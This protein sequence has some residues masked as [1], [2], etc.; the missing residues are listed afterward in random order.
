MLIFKDTKYIK[1][2]FDNEAELEKVVIDNYEY[3]FGPDSFYLPK[4]LIKT[5]DGAGTIPDGFAID[6][7]LKKWYVV[8]AELG[9][10]DVWNHIAK[11]VSKQIVASLQLTTKQKLEDISAEL[12]EKDEYTKDKFSNLGISS[13]NVRK[14]IRDILH[15]DPIIGI[16]IDIIPNDL[17]EWARQQRHKVKLW[18]ISKFVEFNNSTNIVY[19]FPEEFKPAL[20]TEEE[21]KPQKANTEVT[22]YDVEISDLILANLLVIG[23]TLIMT[24]K[25]RNGE[26]KNYEAKILEDGSIEVLGQQFSSP[27]YGALAGIQDAGSNR[28][29][30]NGWTSWKT[31]Q[32][33]TLAELRDQLLNTKTIN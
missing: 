10:H 6:L 27:S 9:H 23:Q 8:E 22:K 24:Y 20:D 16:P 2:P 12:Y 14:V 28:K 17:K 18:I 4:T 7:G 19:E 1:S 29:T 3:L 25:P 32:N 21:S 11:Q 13:V 5:P 30:V 33:K 26:I 31:N 15:E